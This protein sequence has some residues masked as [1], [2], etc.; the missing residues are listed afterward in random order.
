MFTS[1]DVKTRQFGQIK[2]AAVVGNHCYFLC[3]KEVACVTL[4]TKIH[5]QVG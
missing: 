5:V 3:G 1:C 4:G 2:A